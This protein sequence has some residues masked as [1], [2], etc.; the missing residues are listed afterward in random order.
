MSIIH[1]LRSTG[2]PTTTPTCTRPNVIPVPGATSAP[3]LVPTT[4]V[5]PELDLKEKYGKFVAA[6]EAMT[7][8]VSSPPPVTVP[9]PVE[10]PPSQGAARPKWPDVLPNVVLPS[11][12]AF[13]PR[14]PPAVERV[15]GVIVGVINSLYKEKAKWRYTSQP[16]PE[17]RGYYLDQDIWCWISIPNGDFPIRPFFYVN[18]QPLPD[19]NGTE[20][21]LIMDTMK[22]VFAGEGASKEEEAERA[23]EQVGQ[24]MEYIRKRK[25]EKGAVVIDPEKIQRVAKRYAP[26]F[27]NT[28]PLITTPL[29][30]PLPPAPPVPEQPSEPIECAAPPP[31]EEPPPPI[32][33]KPVPV[34]PTIRA[35]ISPA[36]TPVFNPSS[37]PASEWTPPTERVTYCVLGIV[38][39]MSGATTKW[40][41][42]HVPAPAVKGTYLDHEIW[43]WLSRYD[44]TPTLYVDEKNQPLSLAEKNLLASTLKHFFTEPYERGPSSR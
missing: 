38:Q 21:N 15:R 43:L 30:L 27:P 32:P 7:P 5:E 37:S 3:A 2:K 17:I 12:P 19:L 25:R 10:T 22:R 16:T 8:A 31:A 36:A 26:V 20:K 18:H 23:R 41:Y 1:G 13:G 4:T 24:L 28:P 33:P 39:S 42:Q 40:R 9:P 44:S 29:A 11:G 14:Q 35:M 6:I 34:A